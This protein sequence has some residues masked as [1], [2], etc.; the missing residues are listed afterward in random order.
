ML[1]E[2]RADAEKLSSEFEKFLTSVFEEFR[3][4]K[5][6]LKHLNNH[7]HTLMV[8]L[9]EV[10]KRTLTNLDNILDISKEV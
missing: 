4:I 6:E 5:K 9:M 7:N 1:M 10:E 2:D 8:R 3:N